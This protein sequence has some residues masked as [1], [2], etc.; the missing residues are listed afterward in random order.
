MEFRILNQLTGIASYRMR[1]ARGLFSDE[2]TINPLASP[3]PVTTDDDNKEKNVFASAFSTANSEPSSH[4]LEYAI[5]APARTG[6]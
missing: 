3:E 1:S 2:S 5:S 4:R 6:L